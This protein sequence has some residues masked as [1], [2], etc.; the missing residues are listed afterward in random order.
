MV[1]VASE[2]PTR[3]ESAPLVPAPRVDASRRRPSEPLP[4]AGQ[5]LRAE[6]LTIR[7]GSFAAVKDVT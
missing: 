3:K 4:P 5:V 2:Q 7:Y 1:N 6:H